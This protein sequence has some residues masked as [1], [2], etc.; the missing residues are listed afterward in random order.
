MEGVYGDGFQTVPLPSSRNSGTG[1]LMDLRYFR[2]R[3]GPGSSIRPAIAFSSIPSFIFWDFY[4]GQLRPSEIDPV[5]VKYTYQTRTTGGGH[6]LPPRP[7][8]KDPPHPLPPFLCAGPGRHCGP[9]S[10]PASRR[11]VLTFARP[12]RTNE[13]SLG[14]QRLQ[15]PGR[16]VVKG[17]RPLPWAGMFSAGTADAPNFCTF[18]RFSLSGSR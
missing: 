5:R 16:A 13:P 9:L 18:A 3:S 14:R 7:L 2:R 15:L 6:P 12:S 4:S 1:R 8:E 17:K 11:V 10:Q